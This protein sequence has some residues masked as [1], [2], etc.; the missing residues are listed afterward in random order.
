MHSF[1]NDQ[2]P[3]EKGFKTSQLVMPI[4]QTERKNSKR[5]LKRRGM[6]SEVSR[7]QIISITG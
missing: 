5:V 6:G 7:R 4:M 3:F 2:V 1:L